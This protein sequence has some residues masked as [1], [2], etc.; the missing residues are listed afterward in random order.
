MFLKQ[1]DQGLPQADY[2]DP[3]YLKILPDLEY[4]E[5]MWIGLS[6]WYYNG[7]ISNQA[8]AEKYLPRFTHESI[9]IY[10]H[11]LSLGVW[12][13]KFKRT[14]SQDLA[15]ILSRLIISNLPPS[16]EE[17]INNVDL[18]GNSL[19]VILKTLDILA[20][21]DGSAFC[22]IDYPSFEPI[23]NE[24]ERLQSGR[25]PYLV[26][27]PRKQLINWKYSNSGGSLRIEQAVIERQVKVDV[28]RFRSQYVQQYLV[29]EP[30]QY[31]VYE[32][33]GGMTSTDLVLVD[34]GEI[35]L[36][37]VPIV[38]Y[39]LHSS[40]PFLADIPLKCLADLNLDLYRYDSDLKWSQH[41]AN[42]PTLVYQKEKA[43]E[44]SELTG[45]QREDLKKLE[46]LNSQKEIKIGAGQIIMAEGQV[47]WLELTGKTLESSMKLIA[48]T[49]ESIDRKSLGYL[50]GIMG[51]QKTATEVAL[52]A[53][54][55]EANL[56]SI[57]LQKQSAVEQI[58][59]IWGIYENEQAEPEF[60]FDT[61]FLTK[62]LQ[63]STLNDFREAWVSGWLSHELSLKLA[64]KAGA[65]P[66]PLS[67][68]ELQQELETN[69][70]ESLPPE[71]P[72]LPSEPDIS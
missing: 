59:K 64:N 23:N 14:I 15:G 6:N 34:S 13:D 57:S 24:F 67:S 17:N 30:G 21:R 65:F 3:D 50:T 47:Y 41:L 45:Q 16:L 40:D 70:V 18:N 12:D 66:E 31:E 44:K 43:P 22:L 71:P 72:R 69:R 60:S 46:Y 49:N 37:F 4:L 61:S 36:D 19:E 5:D 2:R 32:K 10:K 7:Q 56:M 8:K 1:I 51:K 25:R 38:G 62:S 11:R 26:P 29:L 42:C 54:Q 53:S 58:I 20:L 27:I 63:S 48:Q 68:E 28:D 55:A 52:N 9:D 35:S 39:S 33:T